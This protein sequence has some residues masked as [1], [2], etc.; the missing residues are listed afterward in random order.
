[1]LLETETHIIGPC[2]GA[3][4]VGLLLSRISCDVCSHGRATPKAERRRVFKFD[5]ANLSLF[6]R[7]SDEHSHSLP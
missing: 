6:R 4:K 7:S 1:M 3:G 5:T 2:F